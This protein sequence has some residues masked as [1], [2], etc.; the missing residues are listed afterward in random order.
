V[1]DGNAWPEGNITYTLL[2]VRYLFLPIKIYRLEGF[3]KIQK[4]Q[5]K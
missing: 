3:S 4:L 5:G 1:L 2:E